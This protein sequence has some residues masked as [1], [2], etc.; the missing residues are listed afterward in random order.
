L[1]EIVEA[2]HIFGDRLDDVLKV[3]IKP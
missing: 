1:G 2:Y 3:A